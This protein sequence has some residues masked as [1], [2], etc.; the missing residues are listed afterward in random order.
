[1]SLKYSVIVVAYKDIP[2]DVKTSI[3]QYSIR[4]IDEA[5]DIV[6]FCNYG[7]QFDQDARAC[8]YLEWYEKN[9]LK[10]LASGY[11]VVL[12]EVPYSA[13]KSVLESLKEIDERFGEHL[14]VIEHDDI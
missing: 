3:K 7:R 4:E 11:E 9:I 8:I 5:S 1:M 12:L 6:T 14:L 2:E 13:N 10:H